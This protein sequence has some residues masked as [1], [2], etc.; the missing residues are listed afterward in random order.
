M[1]QSVVSKEQKHW[2]DN[3]DPLET[4]YIQAIIAKGADAAIEFIDRCCKH[5]ADVIPP[6]KSNPTP[7]LDV[8]VL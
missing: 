6:K 8:P 5:D 1:S 7:T 3:I 2:H 4:P